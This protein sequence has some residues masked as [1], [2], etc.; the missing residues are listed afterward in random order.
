[1]SQHPAVHEH[2]EEE[3]RTGETPNSTPKIDL[4]LSMGKSAPHHKLFPMEMPP[5]RASV[6]PGDSSKLRGH[7]FQPQSGVARV[8]SPARVTQGYISNSHEIN[9]N[10]YSFLF[11]QPIIKRSVALY[12]QFHQVVGKHKVLN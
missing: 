11:K 10:H 1:M 5:R 8:L 6:W 2:T 4:Y 12:P 9:T 3:L 7:H